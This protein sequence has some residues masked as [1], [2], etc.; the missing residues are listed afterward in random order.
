MCPTP[1]L[2]SMY[3]FTIVSHPVQRR[4]ILGKCF[5]FLSLSF[6]IWA[7]S[8]RD[9]AFWFQKKEIHTIFI[10]NSV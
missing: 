10:V 3:F 2:A 7:Q 4:I 1:F 8:A 6:I 5:T 9:N